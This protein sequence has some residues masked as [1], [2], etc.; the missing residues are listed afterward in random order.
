MGPRGRGRGRGGGGGG[1]GGRGGGF[2]GGRGGG[3]G[4]GRG[5]GGGRGGAFRGRGGARGR[6]RGR[7]APRGGTGPRFETSRV[8]EEASSEEES[9]GEEEDYESEDGEGE[10]LEGSDSEDDEEQTQKAARPYMALLQGFTDDS[11]RNAKRRK[12]DSGAAAKEPDLGSAPLDDE[13]EDDDAEEKEPEDLDLVEEAEEDPAVAH[14]E[15]EDDIDVDDNDEDE[16]DATDPFD[17]HFTSPDE[18]LT[19]QRV[20]AVQ[21][22]EWATSRHVTK[23]SRAVLMSPKVDGAEEAKL[24]SP[25]TGPD[26]LKL[27]MKLKE[28]VSRKLPSFDPV[29]QSLAPMLFNYQ[30]ILFGDRNVRNSDSLRQI[31]C[32]HA[33]NH[34]LKTRDRVIKNTYKLSKEDNPDLECRDQGFVRPKVLFLLPTR[35]SCAKMVSTIEDLLE[36]A[37]KENRKRF[38]DAYVDTSEKFR[39]NKPADFLELFDGNDD[40]MFRLGVK[41]TRKTI[42]YFAQFYNSDILMASPLGLRMAIGSVEDKKATDYDFLSSIEMVIVDQADGLLNQNWEHVEYIFEHLNL[43]PKDAHGCD[44]SRVRSW[45]LEDWAR[46]FRQTVVLAPFL[47]PE[48]TELQ[49]TQCHNWAGKVRFQPACAGLLQQLPVRARQTFSRFEAASAERDPDARFAYFTSAIV[50]ALLRRGKDVA[51]TLIFVPSYLDFVRVRNYFATADA[52]ASLSFGNISEYADAT[53]AARARSH[54]L[55][56]RHKVLLYTERAHH[57]RR[58]RLRGVRRV[59]MYGLPENP[60]FYREIAGDYLAKSEEEMRLEAGQGTV[61]VMFSRY[62]VMKLERIVGSQRVGK[63][64]QERGDTFDFV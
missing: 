25:I 47:T 32:L 54:F 9:S 39:D 1:G 48:L 28:V 45:Y 11:G 12:L 23:L 63:M 40:D 30:D 4:R 8:G 53:D 2:R 51:G 38:E 58:Y 55:S 64:I 29:Q 52:L 62:D 21:G 3:P 27:K 15:A 14:A 57:F 56:G 36:P 18:T 6:G 16:E 24:P 49:R 50:P 59:V 17:N 5:G 19:A 20:R 13:S 33:I 61:R 31:T 46:H 44:F 43:Q 42:K 41:F 10:D 37:Q 22:N 7:G 60:L 26:G 34:V 35:Q